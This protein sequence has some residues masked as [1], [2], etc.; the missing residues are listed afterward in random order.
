MDLSIIIVNYNTKKL[1]LNCI[2]SIIRHT[3]EMVYEIIVVDNGSTDGSMYLLQRDESILALKKKKLIKLIRLNKN[4]GFGTANNRGLRVA[5]GKQILFL[6]SDT[7]LSDNLLKETVN[8]MN[9]NRNIGVL[10]CSLLNRDGSLQGTGG[11]FPTLPKVFFWMMF[12]EDIPFV[13]KVLK[14]FHPVHVNS[15]FYKGTNL[16]IKETELDWVTGAFLQTRS[17]I[18]KEVGGFDE[19]YFMYTEEVDLCY[20]IKNAGW[21]V[22]YNPKWSIIH[23]GGASGDKEFS[24]INEYKGIL[25]FY[26]KHMPKW[27]K[28]IARILLKLGS[29]LRIPILGLVK[30]KPAARIYAKAYKTI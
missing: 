19:D 23:F 7:I 25:T 3:K 4:L 14:P 30:G 28:K 24:T 29:L 16:Y 11:Y 5:E 1:T 17:D 18:L 27:Q 13:D 20:R 26:D 22:K 21:I 6:N 2:K 9:K 8:Y 15:P 10:S 12:I